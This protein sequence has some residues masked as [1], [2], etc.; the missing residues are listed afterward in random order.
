MPIT[1]GNLLVISDRSDSNTGDAAELSPLTGAVISQLTL[2]FANKG[3]IL[4]SGIFA[5]AKESISSSNLDGV[6]IYSN[7]A[8]TLIALVPTPFPAYAGTIAW[9]SPIRAWGAATFYILARPRTGGIDPILY[10][11]SDAGVVSATTWTLP[12][13]ARS[14][15]SIAVSL[16]GTKVYYNEGVS[17]R[18]LHVYDLTNSVALPNLVAAAVGVNFSGD[19]FVTSTGDVLALTKVVAWEVRR[20]NSS[21]ALQAT[22]ALDTS[23]YENPEMATD[24]DPDLFWTRTFETTGNTSL[25]RQIRIS[26]GTVETTFTVTDLEGGGDVPKTCPFFRA[27]EVAADVVDPPATW[28]LIGINLSYQRLEGLKRSDP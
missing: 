4:P 17:N 21:G 10:A 2:P 19:L 26:D 11:I 27:R 15:E 9:A 1:L 16:D 18:A 12:S 5:L 25:F 3:D 13:N 6:A 14:A 23:P 24:P 8:S 7:D 20:Y 28:R 22:Y